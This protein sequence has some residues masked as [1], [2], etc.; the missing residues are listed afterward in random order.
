MISMVPS[1]RLILSPIPNFYI[2]HNIPSGEQVQ[3][4]AGAVG[5][6]DWHAYLAQAENYMIPAIAYLFGVCQTSTLNRA[7]TALPHLYHSY[8]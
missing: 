4:V 3:A 7:L 6:L 8:L 5:L 2:K 1:I